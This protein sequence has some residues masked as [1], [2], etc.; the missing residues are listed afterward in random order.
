MLQDVIE[1][2]ETAQA[3]VTALAN[4]FLYGKDFATPERADLIS[5]IL[6]VAYSDVVPGQKA[7]AQFTI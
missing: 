7:L 1:T 4:E 6:A 3:E 5:D 2:L